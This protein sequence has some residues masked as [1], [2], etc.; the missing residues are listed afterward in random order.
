MRSGG[1]HIQRCV[2]VRHGPYQL[3]ARVRCGTGKQ[4]GSR[5]AVL[6]A[7]Q[8]ALLSHHVDAVHDALPCL[9]IGLVEAH[10]EV[11][12]AVHTRLTPAGQAATREADLRTS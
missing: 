2:V 4:H 5:C 10:G 9:D 8:P 6:A 12:P 11:T 3:N 7:H 1:N